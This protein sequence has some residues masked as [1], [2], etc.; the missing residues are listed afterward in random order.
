MYHE[1]IKLSWTYDLASFLKT[2]DI[3]VSCYGAAVGEP[4]ET[5]T[6]PP[7]EQETVAETSLEAGTEDAAQNLESST[8]SD[9]APHTEPVA[10]SVTKTEETA[11]PAK[12][13]EPEGGV[14]ADSESE[15]SLSLLLL[16]VTPAIFSNIFKIVCTERRVYHLNSSLNI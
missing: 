10:E 12:A 14:V 16:V 3:F 5:D 11:S 1:S 15:V 6:A 7:T 13:E 4:T 8:Q 2:N 9:S